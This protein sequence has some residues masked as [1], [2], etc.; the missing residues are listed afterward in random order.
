M[1]VVVLGYVFIMM[2]CILNLQKIFKIETF[3]SSKLVNYS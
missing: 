1:A 3:A 2:P